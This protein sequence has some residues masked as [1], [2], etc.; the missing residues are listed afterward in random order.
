MIEVGSKVAL[1]ATPHILLGTVEAACQDRKDVGRAGEYIFWLGTGQKNKLFK[2]ADTDVVLFEEDIGTF[3]VF[4]PQG[5]APTV[6]H[7]NRKSA[8]N[9]A[10]RLAKLNAGQS[11]Y[12]L[13]AV[14]EYTT[15]PITVIHK[16]LP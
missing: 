2:N 5:R 15:A 7:N 6:L 4:N 1:A 12:V 16:E 10:E 11:F 13:Q 9:E 14:D 3:Y 8:Q